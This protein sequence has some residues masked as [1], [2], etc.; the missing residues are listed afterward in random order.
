M[1][2]WRRRSFIKTLLLS[3]LS[4]SALGALKKKKLKDKKM[5]TSSTHK[6]PVLFF[7]HGSPMNA[8]AHNDYTKALSTA[9]ANLPTPKAI[10]MISAHW[11]T[12][13]TWVT[14]MQKP[15]TIHDF[16]GFPNELY[17]I[18]YPAAGNPEIAREI[19]NHITSPHIGADETEW[20]LDHGAWSV[21]RHV[22]PKADIPV[23]QLSMDMTKPAEYHFELGEKLKF[24]RKQGVLIIGSGNITHNLRIFD[25]KENAPLLS[26][27]VEFD[28]WV[29]EKLKT[30][31]FK[32]LVSEYLKNKNGPIAQPTPDHYYPLL[33]V[34]GAV[35]EKDKLEFIYE[36][37]Q[38]ASISMRSFKFQ[39]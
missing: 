5:E 11:M 3:G 16:G 26:W 9:A 4:F 21:L 10:L 1:D 29:T 12:R 22:Y 28:Q 20:G 6:M 39:G 8:I 34:L 13:G 38:N 30:R 7:G 25:W 19:I 32:P 17:Q 14:A 18:E 23:I 36:G 37:I 24:L 2:N 33:Y 27:A 31:D 15:K 35:D